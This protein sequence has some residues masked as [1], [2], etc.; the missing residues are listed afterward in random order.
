MDGGWVDRVLGR[1]L[2]RPQHGGTTRDA[3]CWGRGGWGSAC[4]RWSRRPA[5]H[6]ETRGTDGDATAA[7]LD[8][9]VGGSCPFL[10]VGPFPGGLPPCLALADR[11]SWA[12]VMTA[13]PRGRTSSLTCPLGAQWF[14][15][16]SPRGAR[17]GRWPR[18]AS[19]R[20]RPHRRRRRHFSSGAAPTAV[21]S[22][23]CYRRPRRPP[24]GLR[25]AVST[26]APRRL[27]RLLPRPRYVAI[28]VHKRIP[29]ARA[30]PSPGSYT[31]C[32]F[33]TGR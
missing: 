29:N 6:H 8:R 21:G 5:H 26:A 20:G 15:F 23:G 16:L 17:R 3:F 13:M 9:V 10:P 18:R 25:P 1:S 4:R 19:L 28:T 30:A 32:V 24:G 22:G 12:L 14:R 33:P 31:R 7:H 11:V 27:S 2:G